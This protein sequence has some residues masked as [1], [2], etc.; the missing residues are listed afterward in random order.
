ML[1]RVFGPLA[2]AASLAAAML[3]F[4]APALAQALP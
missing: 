2:V 3:G 1:T 4:A